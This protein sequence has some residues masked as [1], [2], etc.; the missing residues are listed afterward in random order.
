MFIKTDINKLKNAGEIDKLIQ[1]LKHRRPQVREDAL[2]AL[3]EISPKKDNVI[4][5]MRSAL[6]D[7]NINVRTRAALVFARM[8]D[9]SVSDNLIEIIT[10][11]SLNEQI[12]LL[13][14]LPHFYS[15]KNEKLT[16]I[17][18]IALNDKKPT[19]QIEAI[20]SIGEMEME[21]M[22][23]YL[24]DFAN[25]SVTKFRLET[26]ITLGR[27]KNPI[28]VDVLIGALTDSNP[29]VRKSAEE[30]LRKIGTDRALAAL[31]DAPFMLI[32][33][34]MNESVAKRLT[35]VTNIGKQKKEL[36][37]PLLHKACYDEYKN[38][39]IEA[40]K[41]IGMLKNSSSISVLIELLS[42]K[43]YD[44]R[45]EA[46]TSLSK[47]NNMTALNALK[48]AMNDANTNVKIEAKKAYAALCSRMDIN[49]RED[50]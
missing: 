15:N 21:T 3:S 26:V 30:S 49:Y 34:S 43:Y 2:I 35:T 1:L 18:V 25:S 29:D 31:E 7:K 40:I 24:T 17:F 8:G 38:I 11:G 12:E 14:I 45:I 33:K 19:I 13:R 28:G 36:G 39:R 32:V 23:F 27:I 4:E 20:K 22:A 44:V 46:I 41:S 42:D 10:H 48:N 47:F 37:L 9:E 5:H 50:A 16:Q 6:A